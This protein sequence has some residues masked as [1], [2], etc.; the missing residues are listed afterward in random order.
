MQDESERIQGS[1]GMQGAGN[2]P[3]VMQKKIQI[4]HTFVISCNEPKEA[5]MTQHHCLVDLH[6]PEP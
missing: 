6:L 3:S 1:V 2:Q 4:L 5:V